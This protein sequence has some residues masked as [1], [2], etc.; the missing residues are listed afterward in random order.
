MITYKDLFRLKPGRV[1]MTLL[2]AAASLP[3]LLA[4]N[5]ECLYVLKVIQELRPFLRSS[6]R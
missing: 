2:I 1:A 6:H 5:L 3:Q 4:D